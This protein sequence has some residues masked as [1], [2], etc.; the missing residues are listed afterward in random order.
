M[1]WIATAFEPRAFGT[2]LAL[3]N[4]AL[5]EDTVR[6]RRSVWVRDT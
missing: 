3:E 4:F 5:S 1:L 2:N 6:C